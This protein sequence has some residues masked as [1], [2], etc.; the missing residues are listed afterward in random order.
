MS[1]AGTSASDFIDLPG[2]KSA[3]VG[4]G[5]S[6]LAAAKAALGTKV[7]GAGYVARLDVDGNGVIDIRD[8]AGVSKLMAA[9]TVCH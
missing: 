7:G 6:D 1:F 9:G 5:C 2:Q 8:V 3:T 4:T